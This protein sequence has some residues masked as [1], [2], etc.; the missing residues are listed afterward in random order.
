MILGDVRPSVLVMAPRHHEL[1]SSMIMSKSMIK[2]K[3]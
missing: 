2:I 3:R 1:F